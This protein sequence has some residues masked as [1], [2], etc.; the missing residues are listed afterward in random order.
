[1]N[2]L[3]TTTPKGYRDVVRICG[4]SETRVFNWL[5]GEEYVNVPCEQILRI[6]TASLE[7]EEAATVQAWQEW[8]RHTCD[9]EEEA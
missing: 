2:H 9:I 5:T 7:A 4:V 3:T 1:V 6:D 8:I